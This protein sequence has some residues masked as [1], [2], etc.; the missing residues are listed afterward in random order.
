M[1]RQYTIPMVNLDLNKA[2]TFV[3]EIEN[4]VDK[5][6]MGYLEAILYYCDVHA[7]E[8]E[9]VAQYVVGPLKQRL[10]T[11]AKSLNLIS[12]KNATS[13]PL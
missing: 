5:Y 13:L 9:Q 4:I 1:K 8:E 7:L 2:D 3:K 11:E 6:S 10:A 12:K